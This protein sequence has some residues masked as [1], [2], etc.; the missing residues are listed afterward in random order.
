MTE[1]SIAARASVADVLRAAQLSPPSDPQKLMRCP[2]A[3]HYDSSPSFRVFGRGFVC[4]GCGA[5]GGVLDLVIRLG[6]AGDRR[7]AAR[8]L[9]ERVR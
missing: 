1:G 9:E 5:K 8:W 4:F 6:H 7:E 3:G 2:L